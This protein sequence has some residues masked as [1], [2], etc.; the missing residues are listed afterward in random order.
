[1]IGVVLAAGLGA[2]MGG[3]KARLVVGAE[4]LLSAH[5]RR[6]RVAGCE[7]VISVV[8]EGDEGLATHV[9]VSS[10]ADPSGS[11]QLALAAVSGAAD[12]VV[13][14]P[15]DAMPARLSTIRALVDACGTPNTDAATP[16]HRGRGGHPIVVRRAALDA[17]E[18]HVSLR[19]LLDALGTRRRRIEVDDNAVITDLDAPDDVVACA[20]TGPTFVR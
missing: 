20:G 1:M 14:T 2:R 11:L 10:A 3:R 6:F 8:R 16:S 12:F 17:L 9:V 13:I 4:H 19:H 18:R 15:V 5:V 7:D